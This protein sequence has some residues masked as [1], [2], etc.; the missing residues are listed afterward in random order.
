VERAP[1]EPDIAQWDPWSPQEVAERLSGVA[2]PWYIAAGW[3][4]DLFLGRQTREH[5][6]LEIAVPRA[7]FAEV[8]AAL[9]E[10][11]LHTVNEHQTWV[12]EPAADAWRL[13]VMVEPSDGDT[14]LFRRDE[15][16]RLPYDRV[17]ERTAGGIP[18]GRPEIILLFKAKHVRPKDEADF[19]AALPRL[20]AARRAWL[21]DALELVQPGHAWLAQLR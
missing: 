14:W 5:D 7:A 18:Y 2:A 11:E 16:I 1:F 10:F 13:D 20:Q 3:A 4:V 9:A 21:A 19:R 6:D 17:I 15:R 12:R 8:A